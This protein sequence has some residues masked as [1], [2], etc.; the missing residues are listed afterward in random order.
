MGDVSL[1]IL[2]GATDEVLSILKLDS[3]NDATKRVEV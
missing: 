1:D 3:L 2:K